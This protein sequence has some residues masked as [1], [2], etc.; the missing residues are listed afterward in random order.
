MKYTNIYDVDEWKDEV[1][2]MKA[3]G[4][5]TRH[6][7]RTLLGNENY[8]NRLNAF[9]KREDIAE[10]IEKRQQQI[11]FE[12]YVDVNIFKGAKGNDYADWKK[13]DKPSLGDVKKKPTILVIADTQAKSEESLEYLLWIGK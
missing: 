8:R 11:E 13:K 12:K 10:Q 2:E 7:C 3:Q 1:I 5:S 4:F 6:I 9:F